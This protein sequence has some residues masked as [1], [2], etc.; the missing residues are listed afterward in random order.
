MKISLS[1]CFNTHK[2]VNTEGTYALAV[3][4][5]EKLKAEDPERFSV[6]TVY[7]Y[8]ENIQLHMPGRTVSGFHLYFVFT[9]GDTHL[10]VPILLNPQKIG[11]LLN[12]TEKLSPEVLQ[13]CFALELGQNPKTYFTIDMDKLK[14]DRL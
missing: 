8:M 9:P 12:E 7:W 10:K 14:A 6:A 2:K 11:F 5:Y 1:R 4:I 3:A 13:K